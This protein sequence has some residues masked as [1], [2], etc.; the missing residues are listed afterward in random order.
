MLGCSVDHHGKYSSLADTGHILKY[1]LD[2]MN[3]AQKFAMFDTAHRKYVAADGEWLGQGNSL[4][5][6]ALIDFQIAGQNDPWWINHS[7]T[8]CSPPYR[9][10]KR[11]VGCRFW[12]P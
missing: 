2:F 9:R 4:P 5:R 12:N 10:Q 7:R 6:V 8:T 3:R 11:S 1:L